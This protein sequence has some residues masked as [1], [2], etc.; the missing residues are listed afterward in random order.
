MS[1]ESGPVC[2]GAALK[3]EVHSIYIPIHTKPESQI[4]KGKVFYYNIKEESDESIINKIMSS[5]LKKIS[6]T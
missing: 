1:N 4:I 5:V 3:K 6:L 2:L